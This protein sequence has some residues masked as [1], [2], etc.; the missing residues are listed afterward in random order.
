MDGKHESVRTLVDID[1]SRVGLKG[2]KGSQR[3][4]PPLRAF[5]V[6]RKSGAQ[7]RFATLKPPPLPLNQEGAGFVGK[8]TAVDVLGQNGIGFLE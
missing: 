3:C 6:G 5:F 4:P 2:V 1:A 7:L 8:L